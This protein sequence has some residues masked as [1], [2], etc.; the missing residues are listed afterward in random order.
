MG[1]GENTSLA[2][3]LG[4]MQQISR[5]WSIVWGKF[6]RND[7]RL[8][9]I[10]EASNLPVQIIPEF[11]TA[12]S[13]GIARITKIQTEQTRCR[14]RS[15]WI[16]N[17]RADIQGRSR[18]ISAYDY[19]VL[20]V[21]ELIGRQADIAR[22]DICCVV[23]SGEVSEDIIF[24]LERDGVEHRYTSD[25][26]HE[27][28]RW[29]WSRKPE[30]VII[31]KE[32]EQEILNQAKGLSRK[33]HDSIPLVKLEEMPEKLARLSVA[34]AA[35]LFSSTDGND[36]VVYPDH[37]AYVTNV[38][39]MLYSSPGMGYERYSRKL[40]TAEKLPNP[41]KVIKKLGEHG[42]DFIEGL[43]DYDVIRQNIIE[44]LTG[45]ERDGVRALL[46]FMVRN[47]CLRPEH[48]WYRKTTPFINLLK[49]I[50]SGQ[51]KVKI[52]EEEY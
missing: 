48:A 35:R 28:V 50:E 42:T 23:S 1:A 44:D 33:Y 18:R 24:Q 38:L 40:F 8:I 37:T 30:D 52:A 27:L 21:P 12:R 47:R 2:G 5:T 7:G 43:L 3:L 26:C 19:G 36:L 14:T 11:A 10:D 39:D 6:P 34:L 45:L 20:T 16:S 31:L 46:S 41:E 4:G 13:E 15:I 9:V 51:T 32:T 29:A 49:Q 25:V 17:P 22:F